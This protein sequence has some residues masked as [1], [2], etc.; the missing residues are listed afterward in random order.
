MSEIN[1]VRH[2][3]K[4]Q[5]PKAAGLVA[6]HIRR[7]IVRGELADGESLPPESVMLD[8]YGVSRPTL[9]EALRVLEAEALITVRR[10]ARGGARVNVPTGAT[11]ARYT[12]LILE[13]R[14]TTTADVFAAVTAIEAPRAGS[15]ATTCTPQ[16]LELLHEALAREKAAA[17]A[18]DATALLN[19]QN[20][21]HRLLMEL[22]DN[23]TLGVLADMLRVIVEIASHRYGGRG[24]VSEAA[25]HTGS[26]TH[27][28]LVQLIERGDSDAAERL[29]HKHVTET[30]AHLIASGAAENVIDLLN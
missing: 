21:F 9:R 19:A 5:V 27:A 14:Q 25:A 12:G 24:P 3:G 26:R 23:K 16:D 17:A 22:S 29:W 2:A 18:H 7:Q 1:P 30:G 28:R 20:E 4:V 11:A 6:A 10:G 13:Y 8:V 15:L